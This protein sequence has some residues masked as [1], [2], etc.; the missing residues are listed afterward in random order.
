MG[1]AIASMILAQG[2][3]V[4]DQAKGASNQES[5]DYRYLV[6]LY[7]SGDLSTLANE[8]MY[9]YTQ[10]P[11]SGYL[12][13]VSYLEANL[14]ME[15]ERY[16]EAIAIYDSLLHKPLTLDV[17]SALILNYASCLYNLER[18][19]DALILLQRID[20]EY[21]VP[22]VVVEA[23]RMRAKIYE[24]TGQYYSAQRYY[25]L[26]LSS[27][28]DDAEAKY[29]LFNIL[30]KLNMDIDALQMIDSD[31]LHSEYG[32]SY[33]N[34]WMQYLLNNERY[35]E[36]DLFVQDR[37]PTAMADHSAIKELQIRRAFCTKDYA[38][39]EQLLAEVT[40]ES[41]T[42]RY[43]RGL[44]LVEKGLT[45]AAD[46]LFYQLVK[47][48]SAEIAIAAYLERLKILYQTQPG[49]AI[50]QLDEYLNNKTNDLLKAEAYYT[51][52][53]FRYNREQYSEA[54]K[55]LGRARQ[56]S[57][58]PELCSRI[59]IM[60]ADAWF[61]LDREELALESYH[62]YLNLYPR[63]SSVDVAFFR[64][65]YLQFTNRNYK[66]A[67]VALKRVIDFYPNSRYIY[68]AWYYLGEIEFFLAD[69][70]L[71]LE[72]YQHVLPRN[73]QEE[74]VLMRIAQSYYYLGDYD[75][76]AAYLGSLGTSYEA[77][78]LA[79]VIHL[80]LKDYISALE[81]FMKAE[82]ASEDPLL[83]Q[84]A[85][86]YQ[87]LSLYQLKRYQ[88]ASALY[89]HLSGGE[90]NPDTYLFL[91]AK[92]AY[93]AKDYHQALTLYDSFIDQYPQSRYFYQALVDIANSY[94]NMG[95]YEQAVEDY[96]NL[97]VQFRNNREFTEEET[98]IVRSAL[99][100]LE[101]GMSR[102]DNEELTDRLLMM[103]ETFNSEFISFELNLLILKLYF[104]AGEWSEL[105]SAAEELRSQYPENKPQ[106]VQM[107]MVSALINLEQYTRADS[108]LSEAYHATASSEVLIKWA[109]LEQLTG[110]YA[111][112]IQKYQEAYRQDKQYSTW[113]A[114][115]ECSQ[116][117]GYLAFE[118]VWAVG[119]SAEQQ[120]AEA[121]L[122]KL[123][124]LYAQARYEEARILADEIIAANLS[125]HD[126]AQAYLTKGLIAFSTNDY[127]G[128]IA[129]M[130]R[131]I[132]LFPDYPETRNK[133]AYYHIKASVLL[134]A[135][136]EAETLL[137]VYKDFL[138]SEEKI[139]LDQLIG[140]QP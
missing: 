129:M 60:I 71:A 116:Q 34:T 16:P 92:S 17:M 88:E 58:Y 9:F 70:N 123:N 65:G 33:A 99:L 93:A 80:A 131:V 115:L 42:T 109:E 79:G 103:P 61:K 72:Y 46:T 23:N 66:E 107:M 121:R 139:E 36:F 112:A 98:E 51:L 37:L 20:S 130:K 32:I 6:E 22:T 119:S 5:Y 3:N 7:D 12:P 54:I 111:S 18:Y 132:M 15:Q 117:G 84:E 1:M 11:E 89:L 125:A 28:P 45:A 57:L 52:G 83:K 138:S 68:D 75:Q 74:A 77:R 110:E 40:Q 118:E 76:A 95:N 136:T 26:V 113:L 108:L 13:Y 48:P 47:S 87:A 100:G 127:P 94:Y 90:E 25:R 81:E 29:Q 62:R 114:M 82:R 14:L 96:L 73:P 122:I 69:Y 55:Q 50:R 104:D 2:I 56:Y 67:V 120:K 30:L 35:L 10:Y 44:L 38:G 124:Y 137:V 59:D 86:S 53:Y 4:A 19:N 31:A 85:K 135:K 49:E 43:Y 101:L 126:H 39:A 134:G 24:A 78:I 64:V 63:G 128:C 102:V 27:A 21:P 140:V 105:L 133:A 97:L 91:S 8:I 106:D 41:D